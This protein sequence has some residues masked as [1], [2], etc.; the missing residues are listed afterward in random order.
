MSS[1]NYISYNP[2]GNGEFTKEL[3]DQNFAAIGEYTIQMGNVVAALNAKTNAMSADITAMAKIV[4]DLSRNRQKST[5]LPF[6]IGVGVGAWILHR[7]EKLA[8][9]IERAVEEAEKQRQDDTYK[10]EAHRADQ[11]SA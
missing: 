1:I 10:T 5:F 6:V 2:I 3:L 4:S 8:A 11:P 7:R 9:L